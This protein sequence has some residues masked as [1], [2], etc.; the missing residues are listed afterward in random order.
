MLD[1]VERSRAGAAVI[2]GNQ[3]HIGMALGHAGS[4]GADAEFGDE[5]DVDAGLGLA[6]F[7]SL[8]SCFR[9][10]ME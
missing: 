6:I 3:H 2:A 8:I 4:D 5:L 7:A 9:S 10:S 1:G